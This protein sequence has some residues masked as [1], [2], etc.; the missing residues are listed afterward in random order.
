VLERLKQIG[1]QIKRT[2]IEG[3]VE[4]VSDGNQWYIE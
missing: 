1:A 4:V 2:D 3:E